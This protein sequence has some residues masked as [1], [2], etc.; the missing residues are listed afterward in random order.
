MRLWIKTSSQIVETQEFNTVI[1]NGK[2]IQLIKRIAIPPTSL[3]DRSKQLQEK[4]I[5]TIH[6]DDED[7]AYQEFSDFGLDFEWGVEE[8]DFL[9]LCDYENIVLNIVY[10]YE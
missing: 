9:N 5:C 1:L 3:S 10:D 6:F 2:D 4:E 8:V 7:D